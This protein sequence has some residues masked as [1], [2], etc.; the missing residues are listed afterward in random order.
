M[1]F[2]VGD[3][4][5]IH[6]EAQSSYASLTGRIKKCHNKGIFNYT[7]TMEHNGVNYLVEED[8]LIKINEKGE[9]KCSSLF[10]K[11]KNWIF[12]KDH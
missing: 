12:R 1:R 7:I 6:P 3:R 11:L 2:K 5:Q 4:V 9:G 8:E 10:M